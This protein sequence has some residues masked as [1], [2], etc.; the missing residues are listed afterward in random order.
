MSRE[1]P[2]LPLYWP[3]TDTE[4]K[5]LSPLEFLRSRSF[6]LFYLGGIISIWLTLGFGHWGSL[7]CETLGE[8]LACSSAIWPNKLVDA[9]HEYIFS[10]FASPWF[11]NDYPHIKFIII[12]FV[13]FAQ[14][15]EARA[16]S[17][18]TAMIFFG[19]IAITSIIAGIIFNIGVYFWPDNETFAHPMSRSWMGGS[20]GL[21]GILGALSHHARWKWA[22]PVIIIG[23]EYWNREYNG[24]SEY[25]TWGHLSSALIGFVIWGLYLRVYSSSDNEIMNNTTEPESR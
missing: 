20:I 4:R 2:L 24:I 12:S 21:M 3:W 7:R 18:E 16:G 22:I 14:S 6:S 15:F 23:F 10:F 8:Q 11:H 5:L 17:K 25:V 9:P 13:I 1:D 19:T